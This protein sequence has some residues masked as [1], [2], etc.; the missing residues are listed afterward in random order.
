MLMYVIGEF[1]YATMRF[2]LIALIIDL[3]YT[4]TYWQIFF[5]FPLQHLTLEGCWVL[6]F[7]MK[8]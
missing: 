3:D 4:T 2:K 6:F 1:N 7:D 8:F 5:V